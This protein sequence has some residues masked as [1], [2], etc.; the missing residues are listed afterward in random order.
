M[1]Q[2]QPPMGGIWAMEGD[3]SWIP[4]VNLYSASDIKT[5]EETSDAYEEL[6]E[7]WRNLWKKEPNKS[8]GTKRKEKVQR[9]L[10]KTRG[11]VRIPKRAKQEDWDVGLTGSNVNLFSMLSELLCSN[12]GIIKIP[13]NA[14][15]TLED[16]MAVVAYA[17]TSTSNSTAAAVKEL[18][19]RMPDSAIPSDSTVFSYIYENDIA[20]ILAFFR[21]V[22][23]E[24]LSLIGMPNE[25]VDVAVDF[26]NVGY[27][28]DRNTEGVRGIK[29]KNGTSW[30]YS[31]FTID[32]LWN[33]KLTLDIVDINALKKDYAI[34]IGGLLKRIKER[35][36]IIRTMFL[37]R[38]FFNVS[39]IL[40]LFNMDVDFIMAAKSNKRIKRMLEEHKREN[41]VTPA[42]F[43]YRFDDK[44]CPEFYLLAIPN[45]D[46][47]A[48]DKKSN[49]FLL[50]ATCINFGSVDAFVKTVPEEYK[51]RWNIE[52][53]YRMKREFK[54][55][56]CSKKAVARVLFFTIQS[57]LHNFLNVQKRV[58]TITAYEL[59]S[60]I[61]EDIQN[62][63]VDKSSNWLPF[64]E[65][66]AKLKAYNENRVVELRSKLALS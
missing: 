55:R 59:K 16:V 45:H 31:F 29:A 15:Y 62:Y 48:E 12:G 2:F 30:G 60:L 57:I 22:N 7:K 1:N 58:L 28:G 38:E 63:F 13:E 21:V 23:S 17:A 64:C 33:T 44:R 9:R 47:D 53:G 27:Y 14:D 42:I 32:M 56:T 54:I 46:Y 26:H 43:K 37:D 4:S 10:D 65:F 39:A 8:L 66:Y 36:L 35:G 49:E 50:F 6:L 3:Y 24:I 61:S 40:A 25:P 52:T 11:I 34:L 18:K 41:G 19:R 20:D 51:K 5:L